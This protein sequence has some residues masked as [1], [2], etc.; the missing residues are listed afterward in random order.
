LKYYI[1]RVLLTEQHKVPTFEK[2]KTEVDEVSRKYGRESH[3]GYYRK[4]IFERDIDIVL[5][6]QAAL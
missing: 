5:S 1:G 6:Q 2:P 4:R 3:R